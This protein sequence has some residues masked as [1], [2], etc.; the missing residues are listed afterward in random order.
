MRIVRGYETAN[1]LIAAGGAYDDLVFNHQRSA[2]RPVILIPVGISNV[3]DQISR[4]GFQAEQV[5]IIGFHVDAV[6]PKSNPAIQVARGIVDQSFR[7]LA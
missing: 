1:P 6:V 7:G 5:G 3:P 4:T 2:G